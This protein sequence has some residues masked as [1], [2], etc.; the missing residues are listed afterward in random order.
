MSY[1]KC[2]IRVN[3]DM[4]LSHLPNILSLSRIFLA[5]AGLYFFVNGA[6]VYGALFF[7]LAFFSDFLDGFLARRFD[8]IS[9][10]GKLIDPIT[11]KFVVLLGFFLLYLKMDIPIWIVLL[12]AAREVLLTAYRLWVIQMGGEVIPAGF[13]GK[14]KTTMQMLTIAMGLLY[15]GF[16]G[17][18]YLLETIV[19]LGVYLSL[20]LT[21]FSGFIMLK[22]RYGQG[23][24]L[25]DNKSG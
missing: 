4:V 18:S 3:S 6:S 13:W 23:K 10:F 14:A 24:D 20:V 8:W 12:I 1:L 22:Y 19:K 5:I 7:A 21:L 25:R 17:S 15:L 16:F 9:E 11:D 2:I